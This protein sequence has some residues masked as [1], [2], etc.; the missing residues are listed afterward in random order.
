[1]ADQGNQ[2]NQGQGDQDNQGKKDR[3][4]NLGQTG[5]TQKPTGTS[6]RENWPQTETDVNRRPN[7]PA[8]DEES[9]LGNRNTNR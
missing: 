6:G 5:E 2:G 7:R 1:M 4:G 9:P 3:E 8:D